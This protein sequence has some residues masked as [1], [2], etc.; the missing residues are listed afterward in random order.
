MK[1]AWRKSC[2]ARWHEQAQRQP[3]SL[4]GSRPRAA[5]RRYPPGAQQAEARAERR[6]GAVR[7]A[8]GGSRRDLAGRPV[9]I[10]EHAVRR[11]CAAGARFAWRD[12]P[13]A[14]RRGRVEPPC[15]SAS[16][17]ADRNSP[18]AE[19]RACREEAIRV[20]HEDARYEHEDTLEHSREK[21][22]SGHRQEDCR[23][24]WKEGVERRSEENVGF[25][26]QG[27]LR[28]TGGPDSSSSLVS[29]HHRLD[30]RCA[31]TLPIGTRKR[32]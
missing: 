20:R 17:Q 23:I 13:Q 4:Q 7:E 24:R 8:P 15:C 18:L 22:I 5:G 1:L 21:A 2:N 3:G 32:S 16:A 19:E 14:S 27:S 30:R 31:A 9:C 26:T 29:S 28:A 12:V 11:E 10:S 6:S 25:P